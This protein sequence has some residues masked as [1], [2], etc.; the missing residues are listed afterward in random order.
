[1]RSRRAVLASLATVGSAACLGSG[2]SESINCSDGLASG[3]AQYR[4]SPTRNAVV[5]AGDPTDDPSPVIAGGVRSQAQP[6]FVDGVAYTVELDGLKATGFAGDRRWSFRPS[7]ERFRT[8]PVVACG[9]VIVSGTDGTYAVDRETGERRWTAPAEG[10]LEAMRGPALA[11]GQLFVIDNGV[12]ALDA[13]TGE[14]L[15]RWEPVGQPAGVAVADGVFVTVSE[16]G[17][18]SVRG[19][20]RLDPAEGAVVWRRPGVGSIRQPPVVHDGRVGVV[21][22]DDG[23]VV[24]LR[25]EDGEVVTRIDRSLSVPAEASAPT[26]T[27]SRVLAAEPRPDGQTTAAY[28]LDGSVVWTADTGG[29][30]HSPLVTSDGVVVVGERGLQVLDRETGRRQVVTARLRGVEFPPAVADDRL[31]LVSEDRLLSTSVA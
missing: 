30:D 24:V 1:M 22:A 12:T 11:D 9:S 4:G 10:S 5:S 19:V 23:A 28:A 14:R 2:G 13:E 21:S 18:D 8:T 16:R 27:D 17:T 7:D 25:A 26:L 20:V 31:L 29:V 15:W 6:A 3:W